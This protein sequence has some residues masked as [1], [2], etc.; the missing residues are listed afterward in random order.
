VRRGRSAYETAAEKAAQ[1]AG[2][3]VTKAERQSLG[4]A[5]HWGLGISA[6]LAYAAARHARPQLGLG[7]GLAYG[8]LFWLAMDEAALML[9]GLTPPPQRFPWQTHARGLAGHLV[10]GTAIELVFDAA[11]ALA[12]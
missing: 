3:T 10:L 5:I 1:L 6:G 11:D 4:S 9:L 8:T 12:A 7:S 2:W